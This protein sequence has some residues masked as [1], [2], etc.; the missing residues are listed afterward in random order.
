LVTAPHTP[1]PFSPSL[2]DFYIPT[3]ARVVSAVRETMI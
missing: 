1:V 3:P 2:E